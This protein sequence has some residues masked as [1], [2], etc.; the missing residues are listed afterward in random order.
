M[1][2][3]ER[4]YAVSREEIGIL[5][6]FAKK[7]HAATQDWIARLQS[8]VT[9]DE[10]VEFFGLAGLPMTEAS[11][12]M[13]SESERGIR[14]DQEWSERSVGYR[15]AVVGVLL[16]YLLVAISVSVAAGDTPLQVVGIAA[17]LALAGYLVHKVIV[18]LSVGMR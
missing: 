11:R 13:S 8:G 16:V 1:A 12:I 5:L 15:R 6:S 17:T 7:P 2:A 9:R 18:R 10:L 4:R 3:T 14:V